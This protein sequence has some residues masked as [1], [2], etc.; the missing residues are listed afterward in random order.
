[1]GIQFA[2]K[3][4]E[5]GTTFRSVCEVCRRYFAKIRQHRSL[6]FDGSGLPI[7]VSFKIGWTLLPRSGNQFLE[8][9]YV[10]EHCQIWVLQ[11]VIEV[12]PAGI[13]GSVERG[14]GIVDP[15]LS[16]PSLR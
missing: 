7:R 13:D 5:I 6:R 15:I 10:L 12:L 9:W 1:M 8:G 16:L 14:H 4:P 11:H 2:Q 3:P